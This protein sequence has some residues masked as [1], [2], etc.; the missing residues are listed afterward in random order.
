MAYSDNFLGFS[1]NEEHRTDGIYGLFKMAHKVDFTEESDDFYRGNNADAHYNQHS[2]EDLLNVMDDNERNNNF[3]IENFLNRE[4]KKRVKFSTDQLEF[5]A[6]NDAPFFNEQPDPLV[7]K[8]YKRKQSRSR[9]ASSKRP[10]SNSAKKPSKGKLASLVSKV[11]QKKAKGYNDKGR[12]YSRKQRPAPA[13][14][15]NKDWNS[16]MT[17]TKLFSEFK[18]NKNDSSKSS[19]NKSTNRDLKVKQELSAQGK[20]YVDFFNDKGQKTGSVK[21]NRDLLSVQDEIENTKNQNLKTLSNSFWSDAKR[22]IKASSRSASKPRT[23][24]VS[25]SARK[26]SPAFEEVYRGV[27]NENKKKSVSFMKG[28]KDQTN[29][30]LKEKQNLINML[31]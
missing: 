9:S 31:K 8:N 12:P 19:L 14:V 4:T 21:M 3:D 10:R 29:N 13:Q 11:K 17:V 24:S 15:Q 26:E 25:R 16:N 18:K 23:R 27:N 7:I 5:A 28:P 1:E 2:N 22:K 30:N 20:F 6:D